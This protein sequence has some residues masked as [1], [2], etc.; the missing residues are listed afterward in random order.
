MDVLYRYCVGWSAPYSESN[1]QAIAIASELSKQRAQDVNQVAKINQQIYA[2]WF[3][4][5]MAENIPM[6]A[7]R[8]DLAA[9]PVLRKCLKLSRQPIIKTKGS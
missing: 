5:E 3:G 8:R 9:I 2:E 7:C 4:D 6:L 1:I